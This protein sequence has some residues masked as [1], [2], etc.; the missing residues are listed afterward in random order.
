MGRG[1]QLGVGEGEGLRQIP[2][3]AA[4]FLHHQMT[5]GMLYSHLNIHRQFSSV[6]CLLHTLL[7]CNNL[8]TLTWCCGRM[9]CAGHC[10]GILAQMTGS[11]AVWLLSYICL[12]LAP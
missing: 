5:T 4:I 2:H 7:G 12:S 1:G 9:L 10:P 11:M 3:H 8:T 6:Q